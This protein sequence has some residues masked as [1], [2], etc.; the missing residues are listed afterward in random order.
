MAPSVYI[1]ADPNGAGKTTFACKFLPLYAD[2]KVVINADLIAQ[3]LAPF[4]PETQAIRAGRLMLEEINRVRDR[5]VDFAFETTL[6]GHSYRD[7]ILETQRRGYAVNIFYLFLPTIDLS[8]TR[9]E[10]R[11]A[12]GGHN[13]PGPVARRRFERS[14]RNFLNEYRKLADAWVLYDNSRVPPPQIAFERN[15][16]LHILERHTYA[17]LIARYGGG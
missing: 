15:H 9:I 4:A 2:C 17:A 14:I 3:G 8:L 5:A 11:V 7:W 6:S 13:I 12:E 10:R 16:S 1:I